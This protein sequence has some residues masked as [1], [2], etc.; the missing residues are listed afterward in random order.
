MVAV[1]VHKQG[2]LGFRRYFE[3]M[4]VAFIEKGLGISLFVVGL[5]RPAIRIGKSKELLWRFHITLVIPFLPDN[6]K[7]AYLREGTF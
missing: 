3:R 4:L 2:G 1:P 6:L 7:Q 5:S